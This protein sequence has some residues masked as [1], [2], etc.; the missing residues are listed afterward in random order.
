MGT[1]A[2]HYCATLLFMAAAAATAAEPAPTRAL[3]YD[4]YPESVAAGPDGSIY[5]S[6]WRQGAVARLKPDGGRADIFIAP[7]ANGLANGQGLLVDADRR[8]L[9]VCSAAFGFSTVPLTPSALKSY[10]LDSGAARASYPLPPGADGRPGYCNDLAQDGH[11]SL[12]VTDSLQPR[13]LRLAPGAAKLETWNSDPAFAA[14]KDG[15]ALN[16]IAI[17]RGQIYVG[18]VTAAPYLLRVAIQPDGSAGPVLPVAMPR[19]LK[20]ADALRLAG[21]GRLLIF[22]NNVFTT[23]GPYGGQITLASIDGERATLRSVVAGLNEPSSGVLVGKRIYFIESK[24][25]LLFKHQG[26]EAAIPR[27]VPFDLQSQE[28]PAD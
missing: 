16:G 28:L 27:A 20:N 24:Y 22:E 15:Y 19:P 1:L 4:W 18:T 26:D 17:D 6:S 23:D 11:G 14:G 21:P 9:W 3:P 10:D 8:L 5:V 12:Y 25:P 7:G 2:T 13:V